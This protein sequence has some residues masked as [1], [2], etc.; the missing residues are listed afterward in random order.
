M[1]AAS[2]R[3]RTNDKLHDVNVLDQTWYPG[4]YSRKGR[5]RDEEKKIKRRREKDLERLCYVGRCWLSTCKKCNGKSERFYSDVCS[6]FLPF[7]CVISFLAARE[8]RLQRKR[9][10]FIEKNGKKVHSMVISWLRK[11]RYFRL[12]LRIDRDRWVKQKQKK[13]K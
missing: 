12:R 9:W 11:C 5:R 1:V 3:P 8:C 6:V 13:K 10:N 7:G 2:L 4:K